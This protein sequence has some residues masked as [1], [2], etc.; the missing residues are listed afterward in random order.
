MLDASGFVRRSKVFAGN[1]REHCTLAGMLEAL[2][3]PPGALVVIDRG[4]AT[5]AAIGWLRDNGYRYLVVSR[6]RHRQFDA[7]AAVSIQTQSKQTVHLHKVVSTDPGRGAPVL[8]LRGA[9]REGTRASSS[10]SP[11][12]SRRP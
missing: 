9:G 8:L 7:T 3:A 12:A 5:E 11:P 2:D 1:V 4:V 10:G 6:E